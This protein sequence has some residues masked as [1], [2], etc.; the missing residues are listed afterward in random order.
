MITENITLPP[1]SSSIETASS[2]ILAVDESMVKTQLARMSL[3]FK[4]STSGMVQGRLG[5]HSVT[6][7]VV[8]GG[9]REVI[10]VN[11]EWT[12]H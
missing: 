2:K 12:K 1:P 11:R 8:W 3:R 7:G 6:W 10:N 5:R 4:Y 9:E